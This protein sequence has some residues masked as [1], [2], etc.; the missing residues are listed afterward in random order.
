MVSTD[1]SDVFNLNVNIVDL[2]LFD[3]FFQRKNLCIG[4]LVINQLFSEL[5]YNRVIFNVMMTYVQL[6]NEANVVA[7]AWAATYAIVET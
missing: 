5:V 7:N 2:F 4:Y 1:K 3:C 6:H